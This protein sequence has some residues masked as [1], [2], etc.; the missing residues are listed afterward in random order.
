MSPPPKTGTHRDY[1]F[2]TMRDFPIIAPPLKPPT[3]PISFVVVKFSD[4]FEHNFALSPCAVD[5]L[6]Q[7]VVIDNTANLFYANLSAAINAGIAAAEHELI[8]I[9]HEDVYLQPGW[10]ARFEQ[11]LESL[12]AAD[13]N[14]GIVGVVG[15]LASGRFVG[16]W[17]DP[18]TYRNTFAEGRL[19]AQAEFI[20]EHFMLVRKSQGSR[21]DDSLPGIH[22]VCVGL[23]FSARERGHACYVIDAP[24]IHKYRDDQGNPIQTIHDSTKVRDRASFAYKAD[25]N[26][27]D[28]YINYRWRQYTPFRTINTVYT[29]WRQPG[30]SLGQYPESLLADIEAPIILLAKGGGG[31]RL[32]SILAEDHDIYMGKQ[33][34]SS[35]DCLDMVMAVYETL[36]GKYR[37]PSAWQQAL[38]VP[39][40]RLAAARMLEQAGSGRRRLW[41]FKLPENL[42]IL[43]ELRAAFPKARY[44]QL[45]REPMDTCLRRTHMTA[46]LDNQIGRI[47]LPLAY[48]AANRSTFL[49]QFDHPAI[50]MAYTTLHQLSLGMEFVRELGYQGRDKYFSL[51]FEDVLSQ[52]AKVIP[53][54]EAWLRAPQKSRKTLEAIDQNRALSAKDKFPQ[55]IVVRVGRILQSIRVDLG[56][57]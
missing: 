19:F 13:P 49:I 11:S 50:H 5:P 39:K 52:P 41:G 37:C 31:S 48:R 3:R 16:H 57:G 45:L 21:A 44:V 17:S 47:T 8:A 46:R 51:R 30:E 40:L 12:E 33:V 28:E 23:V 9:V 24:T 7:T 38:A 34:N 53:D 56:Y 22:G 26:C 36:M 14:W 32:L 25:K 15:N 6:N 20:D 27:C 2:Q 55:D 1:Q 29:G 43:P 4:E 18:K 10:Q 42:L 54:F 35:G